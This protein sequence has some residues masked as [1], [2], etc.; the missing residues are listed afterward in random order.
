MLNATLEAEERAITEEEEK[1]AEEI[2]SE[3]DRI[4][5]TI[6]VLNKMA[7]KMVE[8]AEEEEEETEERAEEVE[9]ADFLRGVVTENRA[10]NL[11]FGDNGAVVPKTIANKIIK[12]VYDICPILEKATK[13]NVKGTLSIPFYPLTDT[14]DIT[15][16]FHDEFTELTSS[17]GKFSSI[18]LTGYLVGALTL[19]SKSLTNN[20]QFDIVSFVID[21]MAYKIARFVEEKLLKGESSKV[22]GL[23]KAK[24][25]VTAKANSTITADELIDLQ[26]T[27]K[28]A[29]QQNAVWI[30]SSKTRTALRKLKDQNGR[31][32]LQDDATSAF[33]NMLLG[34]PVYVSDNMEDIGAS[35]TVI[36]YGDMSG[37]AVK[38]TEEMEVQVLREKYATQHAV[39][40]VAWMEFDAKI[41]NEQ[42]IAALKM[43]E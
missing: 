39:G 7:D 9:F 6:E 29:F 22:D 2:S 42:K 3:I 31:Y 25:V 27:V 35:K 10:G 12:K 40:V 33:G 41:E 36:Y 43:G 11:T 5:K 18:D 8:R 37:L 34:K 20:S 32:L 1:R 4:D 15:V 24:N 13:Y 16:G 17:T 30:M 19:I 28:D 23:S 21:H 26:G 38:V 14:E